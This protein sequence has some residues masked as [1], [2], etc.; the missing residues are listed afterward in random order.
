MEAKDT[1]VTDAYLEDRR[2]EKSQ[3]YGEEVEL[4]AHDIAS[5]Q[6][7]IS[8]KA[9]QYEGKKEVVEWANEPCPHSDATI[10]ILNDQDETIGERIFS[11]RDCEKCWQDK[12]KEWGI[13]K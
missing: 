1:V 13:V 6:A 8:F 5:L 7:E 4:T 12:L 10:E 11:K 3:Q 2:H 9:G